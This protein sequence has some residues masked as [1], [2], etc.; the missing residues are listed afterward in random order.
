MCK[1]ILSIE[2]ASLKN[3]IVL[4]IY[5]RLLRADKFRD[6]VDMTNLIGNLSLDATEA[7]KS[8]ELLYESLSALGSSLAPIDHWPVCKIIKYILE[9]SPPMVDN[10]NLL[11]LL[12]Y[13]RG[14][15]VNI[16]YLFAKP[17]TQ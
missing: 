17:K 9:S 10:P 5:E 14:R 13:L 3:K 8:L 4:A 11:L 1:V 2:D 6:V 16:A 12:N 15:R 7:N